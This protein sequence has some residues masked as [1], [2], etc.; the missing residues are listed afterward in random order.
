VASKTVT[1]GVW[2]TR[3]RVEK[4]FRDSAG[5]AFARRYLSLFDYSQLE[6]ITL[7]RSLRR[8]FSR[9]NPIFGRC[10]HPQVTTSGMFRIRCNVLSSVRYPARDWYAGEPSSG[11]RRGFFVD[12]E[13][14]AVVAILAHEVNHYLRWTGQVPANGWVRSDGL[15]STSEAEAN[16]FMMAAVE[17][18]RRRDDEL[19]GTLAHAGWCVMCGKPLS[20]G[21]GSRSF[22]SD[23]CRSAY[24][25]R[26]RGARIAA[27][28]GEKECAGCGKKFRPARSD[29]RTC[30]P[31]CRQKKYRNSNPDHPG[32][33]DHHDRGDHDDDHQDRTGLHERV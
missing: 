18:Y 8:Y 4:E 33:P 25:N 14:E 30:S 22:C 3:W 17:A 5:L 23:G 21:G 24:H 28:R 32:H 20:K 12:D 13:N 16:A 26:L 1:R 29:A 9:Y 27:R 2:G 15:Q 19:P 31:A 10:W 11:E 7:R 6:W